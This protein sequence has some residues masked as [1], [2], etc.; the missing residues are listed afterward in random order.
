MAN[1]VCNG[2]TILLIIML[3]TFFNCIDAKKPIIITKE[4]IVN[5]NW[6]SDPRDGRNGMII[7]KVI[8]ANDSL[9]YYLGMGVLNDAD[10]ENNPTFHY[11]VHFGDKKVN[12]V[13]FDK[14]YNWKWVDIK[15]NQIVNKIGL[16]E[17]NTWYKFSSL[18]NNTKFFLF[19]YIDEKGLAH[20]YSVNRS[21]Y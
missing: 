11:R 4:K 21:N 5:E 19:V 3:I 14:E 10:F 17:N 1:Y 13:Y 6:N 12:E 20:Q 16:L 7:Q 18:S 9:N 2:K 8:V 15:S